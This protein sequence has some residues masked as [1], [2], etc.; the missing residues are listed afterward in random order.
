MKQLNTFMDRLLHFIEL[1][2]FM[3]KLLHFKV[4]RCSFWPWTM[5]WHFISEFA[6]L[7]KVHTSGPPLSPLIG[8]GIWWSPS[9]TIHTQETQKIQ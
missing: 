6:A 4:N 3:V 7:K 5:L 9:V 2:A 1:N 8:G